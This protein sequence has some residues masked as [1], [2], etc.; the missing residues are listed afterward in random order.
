MQVFKV[1]LHSG[2][3][4]VLLVLLGHHLMFCLLHASL[5]LMCLLWQARQALSYYLQ[6]PLLLLHLICLQVLTHELGTFFS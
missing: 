1:A 2:Y 5:A 3:L 6:L 4:Q